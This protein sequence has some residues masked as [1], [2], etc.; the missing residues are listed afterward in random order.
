MDKLAA[1]ELALSETDDLRVLISEL[2]RELSAAYSSEKRH[3]L[4]LEAI[5]QPHI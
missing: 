3:G 1:H 2:D 5:F 4:T